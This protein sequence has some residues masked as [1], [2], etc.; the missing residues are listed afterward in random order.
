MQMATV[1]LIEGLFT[2]GQNS[3]ITDMRLA[4]VEGESLRLPAWGKNGR[5]PPCSRAA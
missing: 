1:K 3:K 2:P 5:Q 4:G